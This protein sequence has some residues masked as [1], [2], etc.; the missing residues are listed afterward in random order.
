MTNLLMVGKMS[1]N[2]HSNTHVHACTHPHPHTHTE[3]VERA[4]FT[5]VPHAVPPYTTLNMETH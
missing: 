3:K 5:H 1:N 4:M 2:S